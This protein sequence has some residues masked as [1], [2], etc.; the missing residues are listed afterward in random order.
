MEYEITKAVL[1]A[2]CAENETLSD[3][4]KTII[5]NLRTFPPAFLISLVFSVR[6]TFPKNH[7][8]I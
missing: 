6:P 7:S 1:V 4:G 5:G 3:C 2:L 8:C